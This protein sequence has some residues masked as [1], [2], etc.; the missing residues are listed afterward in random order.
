MKS[1]INGILFLEFACL[2]I[3]PILGYIGVGILNGG[4]SVLPLLGI[5]PLILFQFFAFSF[6]KSNTEKNK[7]SSFSVL[8]SFALVAYGYIKVHQDFWLFVTEKAILEVGAICLA[9]LVF[10]FFGKN[11]QGRKMS[12]DI[13]I[14]IPVILGAILLGS[15]YEF[16][17]AWTKHSP[18]F[19]NLNIVDL[20]ILG[21]SFLMDFLWIYPLLGKIARKEIIMADL[22]ESKF[23]MTILII[24]IFGWIILVPLFLYLLGYL[25]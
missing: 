13:G 8:L 3:L 19:E 16:M 6:W 11:D 5:A 1:F 9:F 23:G 24:E 7:F 12:Q 15:F 22:G 21:A 17:L 20:S 10:S 4:Y 14:G 25:N 2:F 18:Y